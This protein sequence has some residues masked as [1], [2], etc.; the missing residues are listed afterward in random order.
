MLFKD[1]EELPPCVNFEGEDSERILNIFS[2]IKYEFNNDFIWHDLLFKSKL[3]E[4]LVLF[5]R[6]RRKK[7]TNVMAKSSQVKSKGIWD[8]VYYIHHHYAEEITLNSLSAHFYIN[9]SYL[10]TLFKKTVGK[11][12]VNFLNEIRL[13]HSCRLLSTTNLPITQIAYES[14]FKSYCSFSRVFHE[15]K[16]MS[17]ASY[18]KENI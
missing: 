4:L 15:H 6:K 7:A 16:N 5:D 2:E 14:G 10:S 17:A 3:I 13:L 1:D 18:R 8:V 11:S 9:T 12:F